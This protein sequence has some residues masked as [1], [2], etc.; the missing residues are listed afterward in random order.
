MCNTKRESKQVAHRYA[1]D[2][3]RDWHTV[4]TLCLLPMASLCTINLSYGQVNVS[5]SN[6][7][8]TASACAALNPIVSQLNGITSA[9]ADLASQILDGNLTPE[10]VAT[11]REKLQLLRDALSKILFIRTMDQQGSEKLLEFNSQNERTVREQLQSGEI[12]SYQVI[13][14]RTCQD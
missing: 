10:Q 6:D 14:A 11:Q 7:K 1:R 13:S 4:G 8:N 12:K 9:Q 3:R 2:S 5:R